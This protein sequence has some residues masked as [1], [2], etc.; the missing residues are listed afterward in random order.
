MSEER[1]R[2]L[3]ELFERLE[4]RL[5]VLGVADKAAREL[6]DLDEGIQRFAG[7]AMREAVSIGIALADDRRDGESTAE[8]MKRCRTERD[9]L[10][11]A[12]RLVTLARTGEDRRP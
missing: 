8:T 11:E 2:D 10:R 12:L 6:S 5:S 9:Q 1:D 3:F 7:D 4:L